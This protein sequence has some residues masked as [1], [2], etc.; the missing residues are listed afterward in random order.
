MNIKSHWLSRPIPAI[1]L[2]YNRRPKK[3][4]RI[5]ND[6]VCDQCRKKNILVGSG[7]KNKDG[8][9]YAIC[10]ACAIYNYG[11]RY[12]FETLK[13]AGAHR[14][15]MFDIQYLL[16]EMLTDAFMAQR[17]LNDIEEMTD[18]Q[19]DALLE[20]SQELYN[21][22]IPRSAKIRLENTEDQQDIEKYLTKKV[23]MTGVSVALI[24]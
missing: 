13:A 8:S 6:L 2:K 20:L 3:S 23:K 17:G 15:R 7:G 12:Y 24:A 21:H 10:E 5:A 9:E 18:G 11:Y 14:R 4:E 16:L 22:D 1:K 19:E